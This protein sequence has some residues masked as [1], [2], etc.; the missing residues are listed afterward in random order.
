MINA[1][2]TGFGACATAGDHPA[3]PADVR[4]AA[5]KQMSGFANA[6]L[7]VLAM[8]SSLLVAGTGLDGL[9]YMPR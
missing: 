2:S 3:I 9:P 6:P 4:I 8:L 5:V 1:I 7:D